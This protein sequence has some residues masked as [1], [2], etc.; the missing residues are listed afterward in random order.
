[1]RRTLLLLTFTLAILV[2]PVAASAGPLVGVADDNVLLRGGRSADRAVADWAARGVDVV[3]IMVRWDHVTPYPGARRRPAGLQYDWTL[4]D[5]AVNRLRTA[6]IEPLLTLTG[7]GPLWGMSNPRKHNRHFRPSPSAYASF[8]R[9]A[10]EHFRGRVHRYI[11][12]NEPNLGH[13]LEPTQTC[14]RR[15]C[16]PISPDIYRDLVNAAVPAL[17]RVDPSAQVFVGALAPRGSGNRT[18]ISSGISPLRFLRQM[19]CVDSR[20]RRIRTGSCRHFKPVSAT[21]LAMHPYSVTLAP[22]VAFPGADDIDLATL[23]RLERVMDKLRRAGRLRVGSGL[24]LDEYG[25]QTNPPDRFLGVSLSQQDNWLQEAAYRAWRD[26]RIQMF[27]QYVWVDE[28]STFA[29]W[30]SGMYFSNWRPKPALAHFAVPFFID[31]SRSLLWGQ[32]R[33]GGAHQVLVQKRVGRGSWKTVTRVSTDSRGYWARRIHLTRGASYR[34]VPSDGA[35]P[36]S[37]ARVAR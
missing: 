36:A 15:G 8:V 16:T 19:A 35:A 5:A 1:M 24:W 32:V 12:W 17:R 30:Q 25:Y 20:Y 31:T 4:V 37:A 13:W 3:R 27:A 22:G 14:T 26:P 28:R 18:G 11:L 6:G 23:P 7:P 10:A 2:F 29:G 34:F 33:P 21:G 9:D